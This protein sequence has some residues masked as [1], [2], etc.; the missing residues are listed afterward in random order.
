MLEQRQGPGQIVYYVSPLLESLNVP[1]A[2]STRW[3]GVSPPPFDSLNL[4]IS[5]DAE[6]KDSAANIETNYQRLAGA[7]GCGKLRRA[8]VSQVHGREIFEIH[9]GDG[10]ESGP[11]ADGMITDD[12]GRILSTKYADCVPILLA[13]GNGRVVAAVHAGWRGLVAGIVIEAVRRLTVVS[14]GAVNE[15]VAAVGPCISKGAFEVGPE[16]MTAFDQIFDVRA[17]GEHTAKGHVDLQKATVHQLLS[18]GLQEDRID[19]TDLCTYQTPALF[20]SHRRDG[21]ATGRMAAL[22]APARV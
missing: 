18:E 12:P 7:I 9:A 4:G 19:T 3:G 5:R 14:G 21:A 13:S 8:W 17:S 20:Y 6:L 22:I 10:F 1:H 15:F 2:F 11:C 16:V